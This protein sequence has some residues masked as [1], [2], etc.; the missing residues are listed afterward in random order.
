MNILLLRLESPLL[1]FGGV[2]VDAYGFTDDI[3]SASLLTGLLGNALGYRRSDH[4]QL[5]ALQDRLRYA[6]RIDRSG[7]RITDYQTADLNKDDA[8]WTTRGTPEGRAGGA[9]TYEGQHQRYRDYHADAAV[10]VALTLAPV[11][12]GGEGAPNVAALAEALQQPARPL[13][14]GRK[15]CLPSSPLLLGM[16][17]AESVEQAV[18]LAPLADAADARPRLYRQLA[19]PEGA[20]S[21]GLH[22]RRNWRANVHQGREWW[23]MQYMENVDA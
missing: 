19:Q 15:P 20:R 11:E 3:P 5:Q 14:I 18:R 23:S 9:G 16:V 12:G 1:A 10:T 8:G 21:L 6:V 7:Q 22:G 13:F 2:M 4:A 17:E